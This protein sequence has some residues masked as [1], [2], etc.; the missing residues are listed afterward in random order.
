MDDKNLTRLKKLEREKNRDLLKLEWVIAGT[1]VIS[2]IV[3][4]LAAAYIDMSGVWKA[5]LIAAACAILALTVYCALRIEWKAGY[6]ECPNCRHRY[7]PDFKAVF[8][9]P[10]I[11][12]TRRLKCPDCGK[13]GWHKKVLTK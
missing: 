5:V 3:M 11:V 13:T 2:F 8:F 6:Y 4:I 9:A 7:V 12:R 10:H 1:G